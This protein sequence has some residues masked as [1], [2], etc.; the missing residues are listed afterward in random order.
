MRPQCI[1]YAAVTQPCEVCCEESSRVREQQALKREEKKQ[2][3]KLAKRLAE[4][5]AGFPNTHRPPKLGRWFLVSGTWVKRWQE[6]MH[7][8]QADAP[9]PVET[10]SL[11]CDCD[12]H[13]L[14]YQPVPEN[15]S[16]VPGHGTPPGLVYNVSE[17]E[18]ENLT[19]QYGQESPDV[20]MDVQRNPEL[21]SSLGAGDT[22]DSV[23]PCASPPYA[24][25]TRAS[26]SA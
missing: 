15:H 14:L 2:E 7:S 23:V 11:L 25:A 10:E 19:G 5:K 6:Y 16:V 4:T 20:R 3:K 13:G 8:T 12:R 18:W 9:G 22:L 1:E 24:C 26:S 17:S 21:D